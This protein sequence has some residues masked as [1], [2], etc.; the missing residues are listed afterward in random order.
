MDESEQDIVNV[1]RHY[2]GKLGLWMLG[3][4]T[5]VPSKLLDK[6]T[7]EQ[8]QQQMLPHARL[9]PRHIKQWQMAL[10]SFYMILEFEYR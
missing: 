8:S 3:S 6:A 4:S 9:P 2:Q 1:L 7:A 10:L 5:S